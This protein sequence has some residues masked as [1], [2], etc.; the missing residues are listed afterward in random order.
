M[1]WRLRFT[2]AI[3]GNTTTRWGRIPLAFVLST[4][5]LIA[6]G[7]QAE[8]PIQRV[9]RIRDQLTVRAKAG[10]SDAAVERALAR[11]GAAGRRRLHAGR[12]DVV[13]VS[14]GQLARVERE[15]RASRLFRSVERDW[16][17]SVAAQPN[18]PYYSAQWSLPRT[19][20]SAAWSLSTG[21]WSAPVAVLD[22]GVDSSHPDLQGQLL[23]G[24]DFINGD[25]DPSDDHGHGTRMAGIV[26]ALANNGLG[27]AGVAPNSPVIPVKVLGSDGKGPYSAIAEGIAWAVDNGAR[28]VSLSLSGTNPSQMLQD[29]VNYARANGAVCVAAAGN[30]GKSLPVYPAATS[31]AVAVAAIDEADRHAWFSNTGAWISHAAPGVNVLTTDLGGG[32]VPSTGTSPAAA[33]SSGVF[34]LLF[35][36]LPDL[37]PQAAITR[38]EQG[39]FDLGS[40]GWDPLFGW[41]GVD[42]MSALVPGEPGAT[43]PDR[44]APTVALLSPSRGSLVSGLFGVEVAAS[45]NVGISRVE[46]FVDNVKYAT[47]YAPPYS[48]I[49][50]ATQLVAGKH[51]LRAY[52]FDAAGN[53]KNTKNVQ[54]ISTPG[55]GLLVRRAKVAGSKIQISANFALPE[56][57]I[58]DAASDSIAVTLESGGATV[59]TAVA[60]PGDIQTNGSRTKATISAA[61]PAAAVVNLK[62]SGKGPTP[63][64]YTLIIQAR[65]LDAMAPIGSLLG[66]NVAVGEALLSQAISLRTRGSNRLVYP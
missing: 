45:D 14:P 26:A 32:Y 40:A 2:S 16:L 39:A 15:L 22:T 41:G 3:M 23:P 38:V 17:A 51:K 11:A 30:D 47:E 46:L 33:F 43:P 8:E 19:G 57:V 25:A 21:G 31:G 61:V 10:V 36:F 55:A 66:V 44:T 27:I 35:A 18:D 9:S 42:A 49:V 7:A 62:T 24:F 13:R 60:D 59:L 20:V 12:G 52:A 37:T 56:G 28:V 54:V 58:F 6:A 64:I 65:Q 53:R 1:A 50:D 63:P 5:P 29:A 4:A 48:F 34:S